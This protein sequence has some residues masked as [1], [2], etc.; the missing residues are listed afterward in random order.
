[1]SRPFPIA[2]IP[3]ANMAPFQELGPPTDCLFVKCFPRQSIQALKEKRVWAAAVPVG[4]LASLRNETHFLGCYGIAVKEH[5]MSVLFFSDRPFDQFRRPLT[6]CLTGESASSVRLLHLLLGYQNGFQAMPRLAPQ[7]RSGNGSL[8]I[9]DRALEWAQD[10]ERT[11]AA[12]GYSHVADL[13]ALWHRRFRLPFVFAR[14][15]VHNQAPQEVKEVLHAWLQRFSQMEPE[16]I[17]RAAS[18]VARRLSLPHDYAERYLKVIRRC[19][20]AEDEAG[21]LRFQEEIKPYGSGLPFETATVA[22]LPADSQEGG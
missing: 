1:M 6:I 20:N 19:L 15:V 8:V 12:G 2:M 10:F 9:G 16:L 7:D 3:Y 22:D 4:G 14:W 13:G 18:Q 5:A 11:G 17:A 21:Q